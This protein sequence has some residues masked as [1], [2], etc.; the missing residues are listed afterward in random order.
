MLNRLNTLRI[1]M[2]DRKFPARWINCVTEIYTI[3]M[4]RKG[5]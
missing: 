1:W 4:E 3:L 5:Q 2:F